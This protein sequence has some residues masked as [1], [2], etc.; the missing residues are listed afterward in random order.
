M[1]DLD[2][3]QDSPAEFKMRLG[4]LAQL[5]LQR[6]GAF[7]LLARG[8]REVTTLNPVV[9]DDVSDDRMAEALLSAWSE[10]EILRFLEARQARRSEKAG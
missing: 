2:F 10:D 1:P 6:T 3:S 8:V 4:E 9:L 5:S 7:I